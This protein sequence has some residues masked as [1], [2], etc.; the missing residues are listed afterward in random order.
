MGAKKK[1]VIWI[2]LLSLALLLFLAAGIY[3]FYRTEYLKKPEVRDKIDS[4]NMSYLYEFYISGQPNIAQIPHYGSPE[5][6]IFI[7]A[8]LDPSSGASGDFMSSV[9]PELDREYIKSGKVRFYSKAYLAP[10]DFNAK[11]SLF[12]LSASLSCVKSI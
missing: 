5:A 11:N 3:G 9:F 10:E 8:Y 12:A 1:Q 4:S 7:I 2:C 6:D